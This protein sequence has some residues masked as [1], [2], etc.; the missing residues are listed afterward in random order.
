M[1][2]CEFSSSMLQLQYKYVRKQ[3]QKTLNLSHTQCPDLLHLGVVRALHRIRHERPERARRS[4]HG[5][6]LL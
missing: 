4:S 3:N 5:T 2:V 6:P 1:C